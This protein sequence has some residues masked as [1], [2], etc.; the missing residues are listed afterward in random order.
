MNKLLSSKRI[1]W[2]AFLALLG[3]VVFFLCVFM[4]VN[5]FY[6]MLSPSL[7]GLGWLFYAWL[8]LCMA[9]PDVIEAIMLIRMRREAKKNEP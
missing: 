4:S 2:K 9:I 7:S 1:I 6:G 8:V 5:G 3:I